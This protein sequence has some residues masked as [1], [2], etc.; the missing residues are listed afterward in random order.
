MG[1]LVQKGAS[2]L[3]PGMKPAWK[4]GQSGNPM[5]RPPRHLDLAAIAREHTVEAVEKLVEVMRGEDHSRALYAIQQLLDRGWGKPITPIVSDQPVE[6]LSLLH[7]IAARRVAEAMQATLE[8]Q[9][10]NDSA[11]GDAPPVIDYSVPALE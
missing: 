9:N 6:S 5:G 3:A 2:K 7:L 4:P 1:E 11:N 10:Q 8:A